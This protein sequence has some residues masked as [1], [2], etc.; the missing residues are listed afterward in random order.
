MKAQILGALGKVFLL[1]AQSIDDLSQLQPA[2]LLELNN[3]A[4]V[5]AKS[6]HNLQKIL[7]VGS[8]VE[9][10][11]NNGAVFIIKRY[12]ATK[13]L[14]RFSQHKQK[15]IVEN[16]EAVFICLAP[17]PGIHT[18][19]I[20]NYLQAVSLLGIPTYLI[21]NKAD[22]LSEAE[23]QELLE[24]KLPYYKNVLK[25]PIYFVSSHRQDNLEAIK[26]IFHNKFSV[27]VGHSGVGKSSLIQSLNSAIT[28]KIKDLSTESGLG[29]HTTSASFAHEVE[30]NSYLIDTPGVVNFIP[31]INSFAD[32]RI[33]FSDLFKFGCKFN[34]C[35]HAANIH[36]CNLVKAVE[37]GQIP[38]ERLHSFHLLHQSFEKNLAFLKR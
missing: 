19:L 30:K 12:D 4:Y 6:K 22:L 18:N 14:K 29:T 24:K 35:T 34:N 15:I 26:A 20:D 17:N 31:I 25:L 3:K 37:E 33:G 1:D 7:V 8:W 16:I 28:I 13:I 27:L 5:K 11:I 2:E 38:K 21:I 23:K 32:L 36:G 10:E 9:Y